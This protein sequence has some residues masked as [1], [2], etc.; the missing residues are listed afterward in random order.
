MLYIA[1]CDDDVLMA[2][3]MEQIIGE[4]LKQEDCDAHIEKFQNGKEAT[5]YKGLQA[6]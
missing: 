1:I 2:E 6:V 5:V 3:A 4:V